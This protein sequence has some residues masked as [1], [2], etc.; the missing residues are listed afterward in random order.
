MHV[1]YLSDYAM[2]YLALERK[3]PMQTSGWLGYI[4]MQPMR[5]PYHGR[6][7]LRQ[8][9]I[10][11][12]RVGYS[13]SMAAREIGVPLSTAKRWAKFFMENGEIVNRPIP[14]RPH[15]STREEDA[16]LLREVETHPFRPASQL[17]MASNFPGSSHTV[18]K[19]FR[20]HGI[21]CRRAVRREHLTMGHAVDRLAYATLRQDFDWR[22]VIFSDEVIVS[23]SNDGPSLVIV[24]MATD[25]MNASWND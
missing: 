11:L 23:S 5:N 24:W 1:R 18:K 25:T 8:Q 13:A 14:G 21:R 9:V 10:A 17:K 19:R 22:N 20:E 16:M 4:Q 15:I 7:Q 6:E 2:N 3:R 12:V